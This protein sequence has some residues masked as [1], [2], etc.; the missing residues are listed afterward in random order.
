MRKPPFMPFTRPCARGLPCKGSSGSLVFRHQQAPDQRHE[1]SHLFE[2][3][4]GWLNQDTVR[5]FLGEFANQATPVRCSVVLVDSVDT[6]FARGWLCLA[7]VQQNKS[8]LRTQDAPCPLISR[9]NA[10]NADH[11]SLPVDLKHDTRFHCRKA[12]TS[13]TS[14]RPSDFFVC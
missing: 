7:S 13:S 6:T 14:S 2:K 10:A 11:P 8:S 3:G 5:A 9:D 4:S 1:P 12:W